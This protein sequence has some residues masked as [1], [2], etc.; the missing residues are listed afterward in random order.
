MRNIGYYVGLLASLC[1]L[2]GA[3]RNIRKSRDWRHQAQALLAAVG[4]SFGGLSIWAPEHLGATREARIVYSAQGLL[5]G[6]LIGMFVTLCMAG[7]FKD[8]LGKHWEAP[9]HTGNN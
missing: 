1:L 7:W 5:L 2:V 6:A 3:I 8:I 4:I 9:E